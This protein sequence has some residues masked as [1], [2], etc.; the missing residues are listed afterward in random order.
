MHSVLDEDGGGALYPDRE[1]PSSCSCL[2]I[3]DLEHERNQK[4]PKDV[5]FLNHLAVQC[6]PY[7]FSQFSFMFTV[8]IFI[9]INA[10][11]V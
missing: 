7:T 2:S 6:S 5:L 1:V 8:H 4:L 11:L 3:Y 10:N 9:P